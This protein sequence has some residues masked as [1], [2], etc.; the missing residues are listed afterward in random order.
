MAAADMFGAS[1]DTLQLESVGKHI[2][3]IRLNRPA[4]ANAISSAMGEEL[5]RVFG[6]LDSD[7]SL[8]RCAILTGAGQRAFCSG[9]DL[10]QREGM[11]DGD[12]SRQHYLFERMCRAVIYCPIPLICAANGAA[13]A[14]GLELL[15]GCDFA[16]AVHDA[17]FGF[18]EVHR[19]IMPGGGGTQH[20]PRAT[21]LRRAKE[22]IL[23][24]ARFSAQEALEWG[25]VNRICE[26]DKLM[27]ETIE[28]A[29]QIC[30]AA[31]LAVAQAK[32]A[33]DL[34]AQTDLRTGL[35]TEIEAYYRLIPTEDRRE[36]INAY[37]EKRPPVFKGY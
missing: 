11:T 6:V 17:I 1:M 4:V 14:G 16:Y 12:F 31:P 7:P 35:Y 20:L 13:M 19:G 10:K 8:Y 29:T 33:M 9:A 22:L 24:G 30:D 5:L 3:I 37:N 28:A 18:T 15:L 34:G 2:L 32:K 27:A 26:P 21:G 23:R 36:G 25:V